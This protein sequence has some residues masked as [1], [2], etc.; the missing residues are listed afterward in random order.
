MVYEIM[1]KIDLDRL[2]NEQKIRVLKKVVEKYKLSYVA[3]KLGIGRSTLYR[4]VVGKIR[5]VPDDI[6]SRASSRNRKGR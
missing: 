5:K 2:D 3:Q 6:V 4:Y 1:V